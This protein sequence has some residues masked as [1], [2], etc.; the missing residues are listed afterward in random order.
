M[1]RR[2]EGSDRVLVGVFVLHLV[3]AMV[4]GGMFL[5]GLS[6]DRQVVVE[7]AAGP[8]AEAAV[9][10]SAA[11]TL[12]PTDTTSTRDAGTVAGTSGAAADGEAGADIEAGT[13]DD[14]AAPTAAPTAAP[15]PSASGTS[16]DRQ[17]AAT[18]PIKIGTLVTQTGAIN[19]RAAAQATKAYIDQV[20]AQRRGP[21]P[22][23]R[24][25]PA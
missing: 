19:F 4:F 15:A 12:A 17:A 14:P 18:G 7:N 24:A 13:D 6:E 1:Q 16:A 22:Q 9:E 5:S 23:D 11:D 10:P 20:N 21:R 25:D 8:G 2:I 3:A